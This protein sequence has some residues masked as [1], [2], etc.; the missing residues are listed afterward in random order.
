MKIADRLLL[1]VIVA[2]A[3]IAGFL[4]LNWKGESQNT[5]IS[6]IAETRHIDVA[7]KI[8]GRIDSLLV[9]EGDTVLKGE[10]LAVLESKELA[11]KVEQAS[12]A[13]QA[14]GAKNEMAR[15]GARPQ[16]LEAAERAY[17]QAKAQ[18]DLLEKTFKRMS[19]LYND[20]VV[21]SQEFDQVQTQFISARELMDAAKAKFEM[22]KEGTRSEDRAAA[23]SVY[24]QACGAYH[25]ATAY[26]EELSLKCPINGEVEK[27]ISDP[28]EVIGAGYPVITVIDP[29]DIWLILQ[30]K[31]D[32]MKSFKKGTTFC[33]VIPA[34]GNQVDSF[35]VSFISPMADFATWRPT[36]QKGEF[37]IR[38]FEIHMR[39]LKQIDG[40]LAGMTVN[41]S[42]QK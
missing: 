3:V 6:G 27:I 32:L 25:E 42:L 2:I 34:L 11:A 39:P 7:S 26:M 12:G 9:H 10:V 18:N 13:M 16:E 19:N 17:L 23:N 20:S 37:D 29:S 33:G 5:F 38:T 31:E 14:A 4:A 1:V 41:I 30:V 36:N 35:K 40:L 21:S 22:I 28:G 15:N 24:Y 8:A